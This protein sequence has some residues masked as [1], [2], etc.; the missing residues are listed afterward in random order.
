MASKQSVEPRAAGASLLPSA[1]DAGAIDLVAD[2]SEVRPVPALA[3]ARS[4]RGVC[5]C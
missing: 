4:L 2:D 1:V 3:L 5:L